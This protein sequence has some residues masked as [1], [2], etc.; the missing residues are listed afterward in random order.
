[1]GKA[2]MVRRSYE[3]VLFFETNM[4]K[5]QENFKKMHILTRGTY[6]TI[7]Y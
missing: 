5:T 3:G 2:H 4:Y 1:M 6:A 7:L